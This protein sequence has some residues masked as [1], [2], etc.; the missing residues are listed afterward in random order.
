LN[1]PKRHH[2]LPQFYLR[3]FCRDGLLWVYDRERNEYRQ[4]T[5]I[6]T[7]IENQ[8]YTAIGPDGEKHTHIEKFFSFIEGETKPIIEKID[9]G[10]KIDPNEKGMLATFIS[11]L[12]V[13]V[14]NFEKTVNEANEKMIKKV[15]QFMFSSEEQTAALIKKVEETTGKR[16]D[17]SP[18]DLMDFVQGD[19]YTMNFQ[20]ELYLST[21]IEMGQK[22]VMYFLSMDWLFLQS[23]ST[24]SFITSDSPF[25]LIPPTDFD[26]KGFYGVGILSPGA[27]KVIPLSAK[28]CLVMCDY[29]EKIVYGTIPREKVRKFNLSIAHDCDQLIVGRD[30]PLLEKLVKITKINQW[31]VEARVS[32]S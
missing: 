24:S 15:N 18:K 1:N 17:I 20:R 7:A 6:N 10:Q 13:R 32:V 12:K 3:N 22:M 4:Q 11:F 25:I 30:R 8:F 23:P 16:Q 9:N 5:P 21:M 27:K 19:R 26:P 2:Y 28:T 14:P 31:K 29:G